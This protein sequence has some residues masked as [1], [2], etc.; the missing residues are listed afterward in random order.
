MATQAVSVALNMFKHRT[1]AMATHSAPVAL[2]MF[3]HRTKAMGVVT[4]EHNKILHNNTESL[5]RN[6]AQ[7]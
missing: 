3:K 6:I 4:Q 2:N 1:K 7:H 5:G